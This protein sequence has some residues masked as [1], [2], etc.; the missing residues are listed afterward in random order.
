MSPCRNQI[1]IKKGSRLYPLV[2][3]YLLVLPAQANNKN[4][5]SLLAF[6]FSI[7]IFYEFKSYESTF[8]LLTK[9][10]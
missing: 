10:Q 3:F 5:F 4:Q 2:H 7:F 9:S 8:L 6:W 1:L